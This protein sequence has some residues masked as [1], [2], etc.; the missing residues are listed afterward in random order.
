MN[1]RTFS[2]AISVVALAAL[3]LMSV[4]GTVAQGPNPPSRNAQ[5]PGAVAGPS[6]PAGTVARLTYQGRL[7][8]SAGS[9]VN[10]PVQMVFK[11]YNDS[12]T[13]LW[14]SA[15]HTI[16]P[17]NGL[18]TVYL[19]ADPDPNLTTATL[20]D[21]A[22]I[23]VTVGSDAEMTP[24][25]PLNTVVGHSVNSFGVV[26]SSINSFGMYGISD[27]SHGVY[28][29]SG[30]D[31]GVYGTGP[32]GVSG[33]STTGIGVSASSLY[34]G[35]H[36]I[37]SPGVWGESTSWRGVYGQS[38]SDVGVY[39]Q[40]TSN[41]GVAGISTS[42]VGVWGQS[43]SSW[44]GYF[45]GD[46]AQNRA[47]NGLVKAGVFSSCDGYPIIPLIIRSFNNV[48]GT[49][50]VAGGASTGLCTLDFGF[51]IDDRYFVATATSGKVVSCTPGATNTK[52]DCQVNLSTNGAAADGSIMVL[53]Y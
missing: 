53:V 16:T 25:Q 36:G 18:F 28:G 23:G 45:V 41:T 12:G 52:L 32:T 3:L 38:T 39:G 44:A 34:T 11:I 5:E 20:A 1:R 9:P 19:G 49:I 27:S 37:G 21:A 24:R 29:Y 46:V 2:F 47:G 35:V 10:S 26:G 17:T 22:S 14:T 31:I 8:S 43:T 15:T 30:S 4:S 33:N 50:T 40:S 6:G 7:T 13:A 42:G 48:G 51:Q